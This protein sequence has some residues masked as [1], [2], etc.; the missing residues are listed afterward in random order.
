MP[1]PALP[2]RYPLIQAPLAGVQGSAMTIGVCRAGAL[3]SLPAAMLSAEQLAAELTA[4]QT[5]TDAPFNVNFFAHTLPAITADDARRWQ[6]VLQPYFSR[7]GLNPAAIKPGV[8]RRPFDDAHLAVLQQ[9]RPAVVSFHFGLPENRL[10]QAVKDTGARILS[11]A[12]TVAEALW[13][14]ERG[15]DAVIAQGSEAGGHRATF[16]GSD[17]ATQTGTFALLAQTVDAL[18]VPVI[19]AGGIADERGIQAALALG[20][21]AVQVGTAYLLC[22]ES[23]ASPFHRAA[24]AAAATVPQRAETA[25][26]NVFSGKPAR[27]LVNT[28][29]RDLAYLHHDAMPFPHAATAVNAI[30]AAAEATGDNGFTPL[31]CGQNPRGCRAVSAYELSQDLCAAF[32][33]A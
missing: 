26:T 30:R 19:A 5:A 7:F 3:G 16:L 20:A 4:I 14:A 15:V 8:L 29:M 33:A 13:L 10:L 11:S 18:T 2:S 24:I 6:A 27:G 32:Q 9:Y 12:T 25:I 31:W 1:S 22:D 23:Q 17:M 28:L 21:A